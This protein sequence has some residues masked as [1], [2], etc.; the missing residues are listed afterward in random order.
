MRARG[1]TLIEL[2][3]AGAIGVIVLSGGTLVVL[4]VSQQYGKARQNAEMRR[5]AGMVLELL[6]TELR[7]AGLG[8]PTGPR[9]D[10]I[11]ELYPASIIELD[12]AASTLVF[13]ADLPRPDSNFNGVSVVSDLTN[14]GSSNLSLLNELNGSCDPYLLDTPCATNQASL[15]FG[16]ATPSCGSSDAAPSCPWALNRYRLGEVLIATNLAG[17]WMEA[18]IDSGTLDS[19]AVTTRYLKLAAPIP[20][21]FWIPTVGGMVSSPDRLYYQLV[22]G[23]LQRDQCWGTVGSPALAA[24]LAAAPCAVGATTGTGWET[25]AS[26]VTQFALSPLDANGAPIAVPVATADL[27]RVARVGVTLALQRGAGTGVVTLTQQAEL[28]M[29]TWSLP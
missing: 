16:A 29:R 21:G 18:A 20:G 9:Y 25:L 24:D 15:L 28:A 12:A 4:T 14:G 13:Q 22:G 2:M 17:N 26:G 5:Q 23:L 10:G 11:H 1:F 8:S 7:Q 3:V 27:P 6:G 19:S